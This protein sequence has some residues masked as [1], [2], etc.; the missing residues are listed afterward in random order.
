MC[1]TGEEPNERVNRKQLNSKRRRHQGVGGGGG[2]SLLSWPCR[3][4]FPC[5]WQEEQRA[6]GHRADAWDIRR[7][8]IHIDEWGSG[9]DV[10]LSGQADSGRDLGDLVRA[11]CESAQSSSQD[12]G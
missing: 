12:G 9:F 1:V 5:S 3:F 4:G 7:T 8:D 6:R 11:M 2:Y 10:S